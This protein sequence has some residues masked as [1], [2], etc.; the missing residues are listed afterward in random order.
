V[1]ETS[2]GGDG[3]RPKKKKIPWNGLID[4]EPV[5]KEGKATEQPLAVRASTVCEGKLTLDKEYQAI[6][7]HAM[8]RINV[9]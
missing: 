3:N 8:N 7:D 1:A 6:S 9:P 5:H 4:P 2:K